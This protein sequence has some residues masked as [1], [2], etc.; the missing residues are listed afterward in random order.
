MRGIHR[1]R[2]FP[3]QRPVT[4]SFDVFFDLRLNRRLNKQQWGWWF[5]G[6]YK[7][8]TAK[9]FIS[10]QL[11]ISSGL[12]HPYCCIR[13]T[14]ST[15]YYITESRDPKGLNHT[16]FKTLLYHAMVV[17]GLRAWWNAMDLEM[18]ILQTTFPGPRFNIKMSS[19]RYRKSLC[20]DKTV[21]RS[22][23]L[24]NGISYT[25]KMS[26]LYWIRAQY[27]FRNVMG[28]ILI[29][30]SQTCALKDYLRYVAIGSGNGLSPNLREPISTKFDC[31]IW[32][33]YPV[34]CNGIMKTSN[35]RPFIV[36]LCNKT[37]VTLSVKLLNNC[38]KQFA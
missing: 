25:G 22:S 38:S 16:V 17:L 12:I 32:R 23:Y 28:C 34:G 6:Y 10:T 7:C 33:Q 11:Y 35:D 14:F 30:M 26:S 29:K 1:S 15:H 4:R 9:V 5:L 20:G 3:A 19:Y 27:V 21:V 24:H 18:V 31:A 8:T 2:E 13:S 37:Y 36:L